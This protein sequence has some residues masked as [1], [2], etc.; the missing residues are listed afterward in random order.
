MLLREWQPD[1]HS[2][3]AIWKVTEGEDF[4]RE[5]T[6]L[7]AKGIASEKRRLEHLAGRTLLRHLKEDFPLPHI[8]KDAH[9]KPR[10]P[11]NRYRFSISHSYPYVAAVVSDS[12]E[13]GMDIQC[14]R[15]GM[16]RLQHKFLS[17]AEQAFFNSDEK[18]LTLAWCAKEAAYKWQ[19][20]R[21]VDFIEHL[22]IISFALNGTAA[23]FR[24]RLPLLE[25]T[26]EI[27]V[28]GWLEEEYAAGLVSSS[29]ETGA[30]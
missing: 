30:G 28:E 15:P 22:P 25:G 14:Y 12:E 23:D 7:L 19:G 17:A 2:L 8:A 24:M 6:G 21:G 10:L 11:Q 3:A 20:R 18:L 16:E 26:P 13:C 9:D 27:R 5:K 29:G 4:F 1:P